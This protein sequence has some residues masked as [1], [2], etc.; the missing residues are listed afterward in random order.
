MLTKIKNLL[1]QYFELVIVV[2]IIGSVISVHYVI[3][4]KT[5][6]LYFYYLPVLFS[7]YFL[8]KRQAAET[9]MFSI[10]SVAILAALKPKTFDS[11][12]SNLYLVLDL[13]SWGAFL[14]L[15]AGVVGMLF[16]AKEKQIEQLREAYVGIIE[17]L[18][19]YLES[20]DRYTQ[21]HSLRVANMASDIARV[22][23][24][25]RNDVENIR[26][27]ALLHDIGK[28]ELSSNLIR[29]AAELTTQEREVVSTH[30]DKGVGILQ[31]VGGVLK[32]AI[33]LVLY[34]HN[35]YQNN[36]QETP[37]IA[38]EQIP[39][40]ARVIAV[41]DAYDAIVTD[42]PYRKGRP[43]WQAFQEIMSSTP[44][45]FDPQV[46][47]ALRIVMGAIKEE[48]KEMGA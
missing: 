44:H 28:V 30:T 20:T 21:G 26:T 48:E 25:P 13:T 5:F 46:V 33:P 23:S 45:Q 11:S 36:E 10:L 34:H 2:V 6:F 19:K 40:G 17:I 14:L 41:A 35:F 38:R 43:P 4:R 39:L 31:S 16:E 7:G 9:A 47:E 37:L 22:M 29:K 32:D 3:E 27:A 8:G 24:L 1:F 15:T 12:D 18:A 42:R